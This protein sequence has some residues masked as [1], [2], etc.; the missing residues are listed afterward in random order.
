MK[1]RES[2]QL[3]ALLERVAKRERFFFRDSSDYMKEATDG[4]ITVHITLFRP[5]GGEKEWPEV[6]VQAHGEHSPWVLF[7]PPAEERYAEATAK[8][9]KRILSTL[10]ATWPNLRKVPILP[11]GGVPLPKDVILT[12]EGYK[13]AADRAASYELPPDSPLV[14]R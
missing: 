2:D 8:S 6:Q 9:R 12:R 1:S 3:S 5:L 14:A 7:L 4:Q 11:H 10:R 13:V